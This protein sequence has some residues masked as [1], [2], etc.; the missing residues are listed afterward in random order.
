[1]RIERIKIDGFGRFE[2]WE[3]ALAPGLN[4]VFGPNEAGKSTLMSFIRAVLFGFSR[5]AAAN[6]YEP[7]RGPFGGELLLSSRAGSL[8]IRRGGSR[9]RYEGEL[10]LRAAN[11]ERAPP[12]RLSEALGGISRHLFFQVFAFGL[13]EVASFDELADEGSVSEALFAAGMRGA[14]RL[15]LALEALRR[16]SESIFTPRGRRELNLALA[17]LETIQQQLRAVG[18]RPAR[19]FEGLEELTAI[20]RALESGGM[21]EQR[22][23]LERAELSRL[24]SAREDLQALDEVERELAALPQLESYPPDA[25]ARLE[26]LLIRLARTRA[27]AE[28]AACERER[29]RQTLAGIS[30]PERL[31]AAEHGCRAAV[32]GFHSRLEQLRSFKSRSAAIARCRAQTEESL[33]GLGV[34]L[35]AAQLVE[36]DLSPKTR[37]ELWDVGCEMQTARARIERAHERRS[38]ALADVERAERE[39]LA[40]S[41]ELAPAPRE[42]IPRWVLGLLW[43][44][45]V[46]LAFA[47]PVLSPGAGW[48]AAALAAIVASALLALQQRAA[49]ALRQ[50]RESF[51]ARES[52]AARQRASIAGAAGR[53]AAE[54]REAEQDRA[55]S[56]AALAKLEGDLAAWLLARQLPSELSA[57][58]ALELWVD[59]SALQLRLGDLSAQ[60]EA[61]AADERLCA[62]AA[63]EVESAARDAGLAF[64]GAEEAAAALCTSLERLTQAREQRRRIGERLEANAAELARAASQCA[65]IDGALADLLRRAGCASEQQLRLRD[66]QAVAFRALSSNGRERRLRIEAA[67][68]MP[69][70]SVREQIRARG[71]TE[72][73]AA[74]LRELEARLEQVNAQKSALAERRGR[75]RSQLERWENDREIASLRSNEELCRA[76]ALELADR[77]ALERL[78]LG[79]LAHAQRRFEHEH[80]PRILRLASRAFREL[81]AGRYARV[82]ARASGPGELFVVEADGREWSAEQLSRGTREQLYFAFRL[83]LVEDFGE[84]RAA[85]PIILDDV[86]VNFDRDRARNAVKVLARLATRHQVIAFTC[87]LEM[88]DIFLEGG[89][90]AIEIAPQQ[91]GLLAETA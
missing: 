91:L 41:G 78:A 31:A 67:T 23:L 2:R 87:H 9:R 32:E 38:Q 11:G 53:A 58:R 55:A 19:Y 34:S 76:R 64:S 68:G 36:M 51:A 62:A 56:A 15:P 61:L 47:S 79:L 72:A 10:S 70:P 17:E 24:R 1:M 80:Q 20:E 54:G 83:A 33:R 65:E 12:S 35:D 71:G 84:S 27:E 85:L 6:R 46:V 18:D 25:T 69:L 50:A 88:R 63:S 42:L 13:E 28:A 30:I 81:T 14:R 75:C 77:Y 4:V 40:L 59:L 86:L 22:L 74:T 3:Q 52:C 16:S 49:A 44:A 7:D 43:S 82:Y 57:Q 37:E 8:W 39:A 66:R 48:I 26:E 5:R 60:E 21:E 73:I 89:A 29:L 90:R 45:L